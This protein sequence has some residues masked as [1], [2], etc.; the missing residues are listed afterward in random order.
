MIFLQA[1]SKKQGVEEDKGMT[2]L[3]LLVLAFCASLP[4]AAVLFF[5]CHYLMYFS[6]M[7]M[8]SLS[9]GSQ[10]IYFAFGIL[11]KA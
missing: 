1:L 6:G 3:L 8:R 5:T 2:I 4:T 9:F 7:V 10:Y 11:T